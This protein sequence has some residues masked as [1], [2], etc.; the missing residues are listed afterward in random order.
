MSLTRHGFFVF[1]LAQHKGDAM[2]LKYNQANIFE[3]GD[4]VKLIPGLNTHILKS[5]WDKVKSH[6]IVKIY[7]DEGMIE[8]IEDS[9][10]SGDKV[11]AKL[12]ADMAP[13]KAIELVQQ[14]VLVPTLE[15]M[16]KTEKRKPVVAAIKKQIKELE[17]IVYRDETKAEETSAE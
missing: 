14:T 8:V 5:D 12:L 16:L 3:A 4:G 9:E 13:A 17:T 1:L 6:P 2:L 15:E 7:L 11:A 10:K